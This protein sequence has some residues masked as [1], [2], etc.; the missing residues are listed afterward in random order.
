MTNASR[1]LLMNLH[2][3]DWD[4]EILGMLGIPR[5]MLPAI[6]P[7]SDPEV[8]GYALGKVPVCGDLGDQQAALVGQACFGAGEA[9]NTYGTGCF[10]LLNTGATGRPKQT[11]PADHRGLQARQR[12]RGLCPGR[13]DRHHRRAGA[14]AARQP[15]LL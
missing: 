2:T 12:A 1:T 7:S 9:K 11:R 4:D 8:Y 3:L 15:G 10:M 13:L 14:V 5:R 6:R